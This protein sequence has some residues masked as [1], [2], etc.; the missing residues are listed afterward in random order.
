MKKGYVQVYTGEGKGKTTAAL[1]LALRAL[2][3]GFFVFMV[4]FMKPPDSS[5][6]HLAAERFQGK[7]TLR[8]S[9]RKRFI[10]RE[11]PEAEDIRLAQTALAEARSIM[12]AGAHDLI[13]L[14]EVNVAVAFGLIK[15]EQVIELIQARPPQIELIL[16]GRYAKP[17][18]LALADLVSEINPVKHYS[19]SGVTAREG[20][21]Y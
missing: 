15:V 11:G 17:E 1:G 14:D 13:I 18:V 16:T 10:G 4:Q 21:E 6:E 2:G 9:G 12:E 8:P 7:F 20:I 3:R 19:D 5:G